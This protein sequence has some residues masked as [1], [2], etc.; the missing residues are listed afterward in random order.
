MGYLNNNGPLF[1]M[2][3]ITSACNYRCLHCYNNSGIKPK[4]ELSD[5]ETIDV[6]K[7]IAEMHPESVCLCGGETM[8]RKN[9]FDIIGCLRG[10]AGMINMVSNGSLMTEN[11]VKRLKEAGI[12]VIQISLDGINEIQ[13][14]T[15]RGYIGAYELAIKAIKTIRKEAIKVYVSFIPNRLNYESLSLF[16]D[17]MFELGVSV[18]RIMPLIPLG[19][20]S[21]VDALILNSEQYVEFQTETE[22]NKI[23]YAGK[24]M[25]IEW[26]DPI[27]HLYRLPNN[28]T[29]GYKTIQ[30]QIKSNGDLAISAYLPITVGNVR[31]HSLK[32]YWNAGYDRIWYEE[33]FKRLRDKI[34]NLYDFESFNELYRNCGADFE[35]LK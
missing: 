17:K 1:F 12:D 15:F 14:D 34:E 30:Y 25:Q 29:F 3:D 23:K 32:E 9:I 19:R 2:F 4:D 16:C 35:L 13:H 24:G 31:K 21:K 28:E 7:Q 5:E 27:D 22:K 10:N 6:A 8:L 20:G 26:G 11:N 33:K 18:V